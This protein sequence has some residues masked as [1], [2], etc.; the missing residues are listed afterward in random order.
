MIVDTHLKKKKKGE[1]SKQEKEENDEH[2]G[3]FYEDN[4]LFIVEKEFNI[5]I[6]YKQFSI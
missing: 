6:I 3:N 5:W 2:E 4:L 1:E